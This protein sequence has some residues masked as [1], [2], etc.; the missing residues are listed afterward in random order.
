MLGPMVRGLAVKHYARF[1]VWGQDLLIRL[2]G[3]PVPPALI[4]EGV[5]ARARELAD[6]AIRD[7]RPSGLLP[8][9]EVELAAPTRIEVERRAWQGPDLSATCS[10]CGQKTV[11][12]DRCTLCGKVKF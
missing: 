12:D 8:E 4:N 3:A 6:Q 2:R 11:V 7:A 10:G 9:E 5:I 1:G